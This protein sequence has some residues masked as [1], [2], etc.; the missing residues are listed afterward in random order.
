M[1]LDQA[2]SL[3]P[4]Y[5]DAVLLLAEINLS[6]GHGETVIEPMTRLL[7]RSPDLGTPHC[8]WRPLMAPLIGSMM[9]PQSSGAS[10]TR[11]KGSTAPDSA[12]HD[13]SPGEKK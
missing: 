9:P 3:D 8:S 1:A 10:K 13:L 11:A 6:T 7:K 2:V 12:W 4:N 5:D